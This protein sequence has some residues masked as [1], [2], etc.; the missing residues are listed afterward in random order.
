MNQKITGELK[1]H[2]WKIIDEKKTQLDKLWFFYPNTLKNFQKK[3]EKI[4]S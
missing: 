3:A 4:N 1:M 2:D